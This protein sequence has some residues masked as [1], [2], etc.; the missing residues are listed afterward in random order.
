M[1][2]NM[3]IKHSTTSDETHRKRVESLTDDIMSD[4]SIWNDSVSPS[5]LPRVTPLM[6]IT[7]KTERENVAKNIDPAPALEKTFRTDKSFACS[8]LTEKESGKKRQP[9]TRKLT[10]LKH[11]LRC[12]GLSF[13][14]LKLRVSRK[15][16]PKKKHYQ[17]SRNNPLDTG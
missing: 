15:V 7:L 10:Y 16:I 12:Y 4:K 14:D 17:P 1:K 3:G 9:T 11:S 13:A 6:S 5:N 2:R 8:E